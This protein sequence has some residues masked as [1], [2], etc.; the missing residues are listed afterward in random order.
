MVFDKEMKAVPAPT[1]S[2]DPSLLA[3]HYLVKDLHSKEF[4]GNILMPLTPFSPSLVV[5]VDS[6]STGY[7]SLERLPQGDS[8]RGS[9][10][11]S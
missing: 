8:D 9:R 2:S 5:R 3:T 4:S 7:S 6:G 10:H 1:F 11:K